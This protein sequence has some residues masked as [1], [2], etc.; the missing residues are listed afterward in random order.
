M[1]KTITVFLFLLVSISL[2]AKSI[3][4][5]YQYLN[6]SGARDIVPFTLEGQTYI[7]I[8]QLAKDIQ[9]EKPSMNGGNADVD[10]VIFKWS[11]NQFQPFQRI[12]GHGNEG[13]D[14]FTIKKRAFL[15]CASIDS[16]PKAPYNFHTYS[17]LY[18]W[19]GK[20]FYPVQQFFAY[21]SKS[22]KQFTIGNTYFLGLANG[23]VPPNSKTK[24]DTSSTLYQWNGE[25]FVPFQ[26]FPS[27]WAYDWSFFTIDNQHFLTLTDNLQASKIYRWDGKQFSA[28]QSFNDSGGRSFTH[29]KLGN[30]DYLAYAN[31]KNPSQVLKWDG[32]SFIPFQ[33]LD[34]LGGRNFVF[35]KH[36]NKH[37]L[38]LV[39]FI[40][41]S[42]QSPQSELSSPLY[43]WKNNQF[44]K[45][46]SITTHGGVNAAIFTINKNSYLGIANSLSKESRFRVNSVIYRLR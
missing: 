1:V 12:P 2:Q 41:G 38:F 44:E 3:L 20:R 22:F 35:F 9:D 27:K 45:I 11:T 7:A 26:S 8:P 21:A 29:F 33:T 24:N 36:E 39:K 30:S 25:R 40:T 14:F 42:R 10:I 34:G 4:S 16:G 19:D 28:F 32:K 6:T 5:P 18:E 15:A 31:I 17:K 13:C 46:Q 43:V 37:Y 23:V